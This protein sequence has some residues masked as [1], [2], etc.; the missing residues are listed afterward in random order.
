MQSLINERIKQIKKKKADSK[1]Q[2]M[3][4]ENQKIALAVFVF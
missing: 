1:I 3:I 2:A 4:L